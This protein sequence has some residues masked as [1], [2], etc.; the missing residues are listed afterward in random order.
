LALDSGDVTLSGTGSIAM[1]GVATGIPTMP[2]LVQIQ[3][4]GAARLT[5]GTGQ[6]II[7]S[8]QIGSHS[9]FLSPKLTNHGTITATTLM[10]GPPGPP[11]GI[12]IFP[13]I[14]PAPPV[15][16]AVFNDN[17]IQAMGNAF[18]TFNNGIVT[19]KIGAVGG[20]I[21]AH[22]MTMPSSVIFQEG[23]TINGGTILIDE[24]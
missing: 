16:D 13:L 10:P 3:G 15:A 5:I 8:G 4:F 11:K 1:L 17:T 14:L 20:T 12:T 6:T 24:R 23:A 19:N 22:G 21:A 9:T 2:N 18:V 7:G